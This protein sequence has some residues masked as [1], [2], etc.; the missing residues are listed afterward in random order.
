MA[1]VGED[2]GSDVSDQQ[3]ARGNKSLGG[4]GD[5]RRRIPTI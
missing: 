3:P 5:V 4:G 1:E 2:I